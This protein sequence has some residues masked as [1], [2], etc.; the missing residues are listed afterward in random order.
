MSTK[1]RIH[2]MK[3]RNLKNF[4]NKFI[5]SNKYNSSPL[6]KPTSFLD[7]KKKISDFA[8]KSSQN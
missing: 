8:N 4:D 2:R 3:E 5:T 1:V 6:N 7:E